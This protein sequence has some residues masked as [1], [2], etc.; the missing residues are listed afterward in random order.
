[1]RDRT[2]FIGVRYLIFRYRKLIGYSFYDIGIL[3]FVESGTSF[4]IGNLKFY[5]SGTSF[6]IGNLKFYESG[7]SFCIGNLKFYESG[8]S[9][10][11][12]TPAFNCKSGPAFKFFGSSLRIRDL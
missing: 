6:C 12:G 10:C 11:I 9:F 2:F 8:T 3:N 4:C 5:E 1:V 7:T